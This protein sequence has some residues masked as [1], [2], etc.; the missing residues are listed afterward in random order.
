MKTLLAGLAG[1]AFL[2]V[3]GSASAAVVID[4]GANGPANKNVDWTQ[5]AGGDNFVYG[6]INNTTIGVI[7]Q[8]A[9]D[10]KTSSEGG[11]VWIVPTNDSGLNFLK[12]SLDGYD[13]SSFEVDLK[14]PTGNNDTWS[15]TILTDDGT[16]ETFNNFN[17]GYINAYGTDGTRISSV[18]FQ[19]NAD[20]TGVGQVRFGGARQ[21]GAIPDP[22]TWAM[23]I[24]GF[25]AAGA[26]LRQQRHATHRGLPAA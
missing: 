1:V 24:M 6:A 16:T 3:A 25:G 26:L 15:V 11:V 18:Q 14:D 9:E 2:A 23:M 5:E 21:I 8:G 13:F 4:T 10:I 22:A 19:T 17:G 20:I 7:V 12:F